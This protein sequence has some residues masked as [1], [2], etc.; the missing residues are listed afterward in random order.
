MKS[1]ILEP[2]KPVPVTS[3]CEVLVAGGGVAGVAAAVAAARNG[4]D[5]LLLER[6][7]ALGGMATL[8]L[9]TIYL[10]ICDG[11]GRQVIFGIGEELLKLSIRHGAE[12]NYPSAWLDGGSEEERVL[13]RY[14]T[15]FNPH[16]F[17]LE[18]ERLL[19]E[20]GVTVLY[21]TLACGVVRK[22]NAIE[23]VIVENKS[24]RSAILPQSVIDCTGDADLCRLAGAETALHGNGNGLA[25]WYYYSERGKIALKMFGLADVVPEDD[26]SD[27]QKDNYDAIMVESLDK[28]IRFSGIDGPELS[29]A[30]R[31]AHEKM[32]ADIM[33]QHGRDET[34]VPVTTSSIPLV[35]MSR[36]LVGEYTMDD[37]ENDRYMADSIGIATD[38]RKRG[39]V[40]ELPFRAL[41]T[42]KVSN[43]LVAGR[44]ISVTDAMWDITRVIPNCAVT[45]EAAGTAASIGNDFP[46]LSATKL[47]ERLLA[48][49]VKLHLD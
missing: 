3:S 35:R 11:R 8:G 13:H 12:A 39:M 25:S 14:L 20:L 41:Y 37:T 27:S 22:G 30:V 15:Q 42:R 46:N 48:Q 29:D 16:L 31:A 23:A 32:Y 26:P 17:A 36:R 33:E 6:E 21:G 49:N 43:L 24:G 10:P 9:I 34:F 40:Y 5:V 1:H 18:I 28:N 19:K 7:F 47:G 38:W 45:G 4:K 44:D 2:E